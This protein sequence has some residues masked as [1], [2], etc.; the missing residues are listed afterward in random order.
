MLRSSTESAELRREMGVS[1]PYCD[2]ELLRSPQVHGRF[3]QEMH[4]R[5]FLDFIPAGSCAASLGIFFV[6][7]K[8]GRQR[9][10][11]DTRLI[12]CD[13]MPP[14]I[15]SLPTAGSLSGIEVE[16]D[17]KLFVATCDVSNAFYRMLI[18]SS[19]RERFTLPA[20][21][22]RFL[23]SAAGDCE[24]YSHL[25]SPCCLWVGVGP[26]GSASSSSKLSC[27]Q[28]WARRMLSRMVSLLCASAHSKHAGR[29][30]STM[31]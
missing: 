30:T 22:S 11:V 7:K 23:G 15:V 10:I 31:C 28:R 6:K 25:V 1:Q 17:E 27:R 5:G 4:A 24:G 29:L 16:P 2:P 20:I 19:L 14:D 9:I 21:E 3:L 26:Y 18:P 13:F 12:N 8:D